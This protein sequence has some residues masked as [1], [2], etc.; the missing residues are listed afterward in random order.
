MPNGANP[1]ELLDV[2][3]DQFAWVFA[4]IA[5]DQLFPRH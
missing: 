1:T 2:E 5:L 3:M 4:F